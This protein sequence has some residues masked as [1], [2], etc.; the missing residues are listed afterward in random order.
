MEKFQFEDNSCYANVTPVDQERLNCKKSQ[1]D[2]SRKIIAC[3]ILLFAVVFALLLGI[4]GACI[5]FG[6]ELSKLQN[7]Q[8]SSQ[9]NGVLH[10]QLSQQNE[11][12]HT[13]YQQ[14]LLIDT[15]YQQ[16]SQQNESINTLDQLLSQ[17]NES[18]NTLHQQLSQQSELLNSSTQLLLSVLEG[19]VG[20]FPFYPSVSCAAL[21]LSSPSGYYW[22]RASNGSAVRVY[23]DMTTSCGDGGWRRVASLDFSNASTSCPSGLQEHVFS[24]IRTCRIESS[25]A[26]CPSVMLSTS[27]V[28][29][30]KVCGKILAYQVSSTGAF[31]ASSSDIDGS[32]VDG[33]SLTHGNTPR[34]HIWTFAAALD[35][36]GSGFNTPLCPCSSNANNIGTSPPS[37]VG[38]DYF[39]DAGAVTYVTGAFYSDNPLWDGSGCGSTSTCCSFNTPPWFLKELSSPISDDIEM[40]VCRDETRDNED[41]AMSSVEIYVQ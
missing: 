38:D 36:F 31:R 16:L 34:N 10:Q 11:S 24:G 35:E 8:T 29:Y 23:C 6:L 13:L 39:C 1:K 26:A 20:N 25:E 18:I 27:G 30:T 5:G 12:I 3:M 15:L 33:V 4:A 14:H 40:R 37:F 41:I 19:P 2:G 22:V 28:E 7:D 9:Q 17:Q 21:P 32:Y